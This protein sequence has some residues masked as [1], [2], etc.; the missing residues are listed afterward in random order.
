MKKQVS[1]NAS[2]YEG[3]MY[4]WLEMKCNLSF[5]SFFTLVPANP[6]KKQASFNASQ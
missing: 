2:Q 5:S 3:K 6:P 4:V 1:F